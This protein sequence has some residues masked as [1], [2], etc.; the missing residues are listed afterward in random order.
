V[1]DVDSREPP[2]SVIPPRRQADSQS[3]PFRSLPFG[4]D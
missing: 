2:F 1:I 3:N 4:G